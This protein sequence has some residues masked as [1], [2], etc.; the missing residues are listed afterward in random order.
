MGK[1]AVVLTEGYADW[2]C[3]YLNGAGRT[4]Y[5]LD[6]VAVTPE[7]RAV[8]SMGGL[9][10]LPA[11]PLG[12]VSPQMHDML[13][14]C[15][16]TGWDDNEF[17]EV[18][19]AARQFLEIGKPV[20]AICGA[21]LGLARGGLLN[22]RAHTS[23]SLDYLKSNAPSYAGDRHYRDGPGAVVDGNLI[24]A[25]GSSPAHF[26]AEIFRAAGVPAPKI[27]EFLGMLGAEHKLQ[28]AA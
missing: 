27:I 17:S 24:T 9:M 13:V 26:T 25:P 2:E 19:A 12:L 3:A 14:L 1:I 18:I 5:G 15:G 8:V 28:S 21:T 16:G 10:T 23:N 22:D 20:A 7:G 6:T 11:D 4:F